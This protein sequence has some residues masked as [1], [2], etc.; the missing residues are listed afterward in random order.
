MKISTKL[1]VGFVAVMAISF[2]ISAHG[3]DRMIRLRDS[4]ISVYQSQ[5]LASQY[6]SNAANSFGTVRL[7]GQQAVVSGFYGDRQDVQAAMQRFEDSAAA[8]A[9]WLSKS[10]E[11]AGTEE[12]ADFHDAI[13]HLFESAYLPQARAIVRESLDGAPDSYSLRIAGVRKD[14]EAIESLFAGLAALNTALAEQTN[15]EHAAIAQS[16]LLWQIVFFAG[17][18]LV[19]GS[20]AYIIT[21]GIS[22]PIREALQVLDRVAAGDF[23]ARVLGSYSGEMALIKQSVNCMAARL[24]DCVEQV[25][26]AQGTAQASELEKARME[27][28]ANAV[29]ANLNYARTI[30]ENMLPPAQELA[31]AF[32][33]HAVIWRPLDTVGGDVYWVK[34]FAQGTVL[35]VCDCT[36]NGMPGALL[37]MLVVSALEGAVDQGNCQDTAAAVWSVEQKLVRVFNLCERESARVRDGCDLAVLYIAKDGS[38]CASSGQMSVFACDGR[39]VTRYKGQRIYIGEGKVKSKEEIEVAQIPPRPGHKFY[40][41]SD[42]LFEQPGYGSEMPFGYK[43]FEKLILE[44][45]GHRQ[46]VISEKVWNAFEGYRGAQPRVDDFLLLTFEP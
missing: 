32:A 26:Q 45:H 36:G 46:S 34:R 43:R 21:K 25:V 20:V 11:M 27:A 13:L 24:A 28:A 35:C 30:Q 2:A 14:A 10:R 7:F 5:L 23:H 42:G 37:T 8:F 31:Q 16:Y 38:V 4:D 3:L 1:L 17:S 33:D 40:I 19:A 39:A 18:I 22:R 44:N 12:L 9:Y 41:A 6:V 15:S 29:L